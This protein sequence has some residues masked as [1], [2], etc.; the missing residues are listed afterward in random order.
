MKHLV[1]IL[2]NSGPKEV[3]VVGDLMLDEYII[4]DVTRISPEAPVP[5]FRE[6]EERASFG[7]AANVA[8]NCKHVGCNVHMIGVIG[9]SDS[10]GKKLVSMSLDKN[11]C[12][13]GVILSPDR[14]TTRKKRVVAQQQQLLRIDTEDTF[15]L[16]SYE[17]DKI[18]CHIH[19]VIKSGSVVL[20][21]DYAKG[22]VDEQIVQEV[23]TRAEVCG[24]IV[25][26]DPKGP[27]FDKYKGVHY[28]KPNLKEFN[29]MVD[30]FDLKQGEEFM[31]ENGR[32]ICELLQLKGLIVTMGEKGLQ[33]ISKDRDDF[34]QA[35]KREVF[36]IT[37]AGDTVLAFMAVGLAHGFSIDQSIKLAN[38]AAGVAVSHHQTYSVS[39][40]EL[41]DIGPELDEKIFME[42]GRL[43]KELE[44]LR[45]EKK[46]KIVFTNGCFDLLH[47]GHIYLL[48]EAKKRGDILVVAINTDESVSRFKGPG[49]PIKTFSERARIMASI[50]VVDY[51]VAFEQDTPRELI[52]ALKPDVLIKGGDYKIEKIAG[53]DAVTSYG[54][55]VETVEFKHGLS[56]SNLVKSVK[57]A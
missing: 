19:T 30:F 36:D 41:L 5:V 51:V 4:G 34:Y 40:D 9:D 38:R 57:R 56:T 46:K 39:V 7:G 32:K 23:L 55:K 14:V 24:S 53:Y 37:G 12:V 28:I 45:N 27:N 43:E 31:I 13:D 20:I 25:I 18:I 50:D 11:I 26:V 21:S 49:R 16:T 29:Q 54:G 17:Q 1:Q 22:V 3:V 44:W 15:A 35:T 33:F 10:S 42:W 47:S 6:K 48:Q 52:E 8:A 2:K